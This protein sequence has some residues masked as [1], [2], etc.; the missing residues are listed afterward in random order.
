MKTSKIILITFFGL[1]ALF[2]LSLMIQS[3]PEKRKSRQLQ[4]MKEEEI[5]LPP[6]SHLVVEKGCNIEIRKGVSDSLSISYEHST[7]IEGPLYFIKGDTLHFNAL[8]EEK[9]I[10]FQLSCQNIESISLT[11]AR[12]DFRNIDIQNLLIE[13]Q[14][15]SIDIDEDVSL[16][17]ATIRLQNNSNLWSNSDKMRKVK[18]NLD[19]SKAEL[20]GS[21]LEE[22]NAELRDSSELTAPQV[23][24][25]NIKKDLASSYYS[26]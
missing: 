12:A 8:K 14:N 26:R 25:C 11:D 17:S 22:L 7:K 23:L 20:S 18:I 21:Q 4:E 3:N 6:I 13:A 10:Y 16:L 2:L 24:Q 19:H 5:A 15:S 1:I 9:N